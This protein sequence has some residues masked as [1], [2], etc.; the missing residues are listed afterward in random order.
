MKQLIF[1]LLLLAVTTAFAKDYVKDAEPAI[2]EV[3]YTRTAVN[4]TTKRN[5]HFSRDPVM[6]RIGKNKSVFCG[7]KRL[8]QDS[9]MVCDPAS[10][11]AMDQARTMSGKRDDTQLACGYY[12]NYIYKNIPEGKATERCYFDM[13]RWQYSEDWEKPEWAIGDSTKTILGYECVEAIADY[14]GRRWTA[15]FAPEI[16]IQDGPW[17]LCGLPGLIL[18]AYDANNDYIFEANGLVQNPNSEVGIFTYDD[19]WGLTTVTRDKFFNNWWKFQHSNFAAKIQAAYGV[20]TTST[21]EKS[22]VNFDKEE[23]NYPHDL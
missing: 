20:G 19:K 14:R 23:T 4:D 12:W 13:E 6:L 1:I 22:E 2:L 10:F 18:E 11:W 5:S 16:P 8:W 7:T 17:K 3:H 21:N 15:W 9:I